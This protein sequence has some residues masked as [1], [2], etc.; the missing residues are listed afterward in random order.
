[1]PKTTVL[2][3]GLLVLGMVA[4]LLTGCEEKKETVDVN[5]FPTECLKNCALAFNGCNKLSRNENDTKRCQ[6]Y[7]DRC[8]G[9]CERKDRPAPVPVP[10]PTEAPKEQP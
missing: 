8:T 10:A 6:Q 1:M 7:F 2:F 4:F 3:V 5:Q 9:D